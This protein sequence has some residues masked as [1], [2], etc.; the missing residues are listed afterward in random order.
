LREPQFGP[1]CSDAIHQR[2]GVVCIS[3]P[4]V[5][6]E[7]D[8]IEPVLPKSDLDTGV[9]KLMERSFSKWAVILRRRGGNYWRLSN[10]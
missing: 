4:D 3:I 9:K 8:V 2:A 6:K 1:M 5:D 10:L 7:M